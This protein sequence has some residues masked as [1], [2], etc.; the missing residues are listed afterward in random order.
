MTGSLPFPL[1]TTSV[2][3]PFE[4]PWTTTSISTG[5]GTM[6]RA[7][8]PRLDTLQL[9]S[10]LPAARIADDSDSP[11]PRLSGVR[12]RDPEDWGDLHFRRLRRFVCPKNAPQGRRLLSL[13]P[14]V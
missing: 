3:N 4:A 10:H 9:R 12:R 1:R 7:E 6:P 5:I 2:G 8:L 13:A 11:L 14:E